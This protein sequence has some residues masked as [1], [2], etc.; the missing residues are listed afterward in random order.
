MDF[1]IP[2]ESKGPRVME[3][4]IETTPNLKFKEATT[5]EAI[6]VAGKQMTVLQHEEGLLRTVV[7]SSSN[8]NT[9]KTGRIVTYRFEK[10][11]DA[12]AQ[13][14]ILT[15]RPIFAP[16]EVNEGLLVSDPLEI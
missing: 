8:I 5:G 4:F 16:A 13:L 1:S 15:E 12:V 6:T 3:L 2:E 9:L 11:D 14:E 7:L 10:K